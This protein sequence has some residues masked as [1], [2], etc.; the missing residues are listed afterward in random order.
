MLLAAAGAMLLV[1]EGVLA[2][3][4]PLCRWLPELRR[5]SGPDGGH[6]VT[7]R[8][9]LAM[10]FGIGV[11]FAGIS[12]VN[13]HLRRQGV[14]TNGFSDSSDEFMRRLS[15]VPHAAR[16]GERWLYHTG[17]DV[18]GV[19]IERVSGQRLCRFLAERL[20]EPLGML[21]TGF[22]LTADQ[23]NRLAT[24]YAE[25]A[26]GTWIALEDSRP[27]IAADRMDQAGS[28]LL[29]TARDLAAFG[30]MM[31]DGGCV[32]ER[33]IL[34]EGAI[35]E[36]KSEQVSE[37][38]KARSPVYPGFWE[39]HSWGLG[40][41]IAIAPNTVSQI[42]GRFGWWGAMGTALY[43]DPA[44]DSVM[45]VLSNRLISNIADSANAD[46]IMQAVLT[47]RS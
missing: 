9:L 35:A 1:D 38:A 40:L 41:C 33:R 20:F 24:S 13:D 15:A 36:M 6:I 26:P 44:S 19:L 37:A 30:R 2:L 5:G 29:S 42:P 16:S 39:A 11:D 14:G 12:P 23:R 4:E 22:T 47:S 25:R 3:D 32:G 7:L 21:D 18:A 10:T 31:L 8:G 45:I 43:M 17:I 34:S 28:G 46:A 27:R